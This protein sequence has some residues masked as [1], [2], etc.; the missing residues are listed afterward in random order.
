M[1]M[2]EGAQPR[3]FPHATEAQ[4]K[5]AMLTGNAAT[6]FTNISAQLAIVKPQAS[7]ISAARLMAEACHG[8]LHRPI[9][10]LA[11]HRRAGRL[12]AQRESMHRHGAD[13]TAWSDPWGLASMAGRGRGG[14]RG[15]DLWGCRPSRPHVNPRRENIPSYESAGF[16]PF[17]PESET[18]H[19]RGFQPD[20]RLGLFDYGTGR[21]P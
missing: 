15:S 3:G 2:L 8:R 9:R 16:R 5:A 12:E 6:P 11:H 13:R 14:D 7:P 20:R 19:W 18:Q 1:G 4:A 10:T 17:E 21:P